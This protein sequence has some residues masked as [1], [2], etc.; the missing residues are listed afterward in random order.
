VKSQSRDTAAAVGL[1]DRGALV[2]GMKADVNVIDFEKLAVRAPEIIHDLPAGGA[3]FQQRAD[4]Y[5]ATIV[6]GQVT[7]ED[8]APTAALPG[9]LIR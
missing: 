6:S 9:R 7:Y 3:R 1:T 2:P 8:G 5:L 4:G